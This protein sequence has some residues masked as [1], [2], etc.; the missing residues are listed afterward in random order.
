M[1]LEGKIALVTGANTGIGRFTALHLARAGATVLI[2]GRSAERIAPVLDEIRSA[3]GKAE[4]LFADLASL[5]TI[6]PM[7]ERAAELAG[8]AIDIVVLNA[9]LAKSFF[10]T[11]DA[12]EMTGVRRCCYCRLAICSAFRIGACPFVFPPLCPNAIAACLRM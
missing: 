1:K 8:G 6:P 9:G 2:H 11:T 10:W 12:F 3:G 4:P 7:A 5:A